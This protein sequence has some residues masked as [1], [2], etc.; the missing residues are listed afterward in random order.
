MM[1]IVIIIHQNKQTSKKYTN[2]EYTLCTMYYVV[3]R[4]QWNKHRGD[5][6]SILYIWEILYCRVLYNG[7][8]VYT[9]FPI[10]LYTSSS[11]YETLFWIDVS[12][13]FSVQFSIYHLRFDVFPA[14]LLIAFLLN[15]TISLRFTIHFLQS[16]QV[17]LF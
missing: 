14:I 12:L 2:I 3:V 1:N 8:R 5:F 13:L 15:N 10:W 6:S 11:S 7:V 4:K 9:L 17:W 16:L